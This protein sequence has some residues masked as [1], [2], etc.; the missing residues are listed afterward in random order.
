MERESGHFPLLFAEVKIFGD[1]SIRLSYVMRADAG[2]LSKHGA[3]P[4]SVSVVMC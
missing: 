4:S 2:H 3:F 1:S